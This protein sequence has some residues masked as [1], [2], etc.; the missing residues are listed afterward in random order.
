M[1]YF[2]VISLVALCVNGTTKA[3]PVMAELRP[4]GQVMQE[5]DTIKFDDNCTA[6][7]QYPQIKGLKAKAAEKKLNEAFKTI[8][9]VGK[10]LTV[11]DC[12]AKGDPEKYVYFN[13]FEV[14][15]QAGSF[16]GMRFTVSFPGG[17]GRTIF[18]CRVFNL[19]T[20]SEVSLKS[21]W[22]KNS[23]VTLQERFKTALGSDFN[24]S[25][26]EGLT[27]KTKSVKQEPFC[28]DKDGIVVLAAPTDKQYRVISLHDT[29]LR[30][31]FEKS[32]LINALQPAVPNRRK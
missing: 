32:P 17:T 27:E 3:G 6:I 29:E 5:T 31:F 4:T 23:L 24:D 28:L 30:K 13:A 19:N 20:G 25:F 15:R 26:P 2:P 10:K 7:R 21:I 16:L 9:T 18:D 22:N 14:G 1:R 12:P 8:M 11:N